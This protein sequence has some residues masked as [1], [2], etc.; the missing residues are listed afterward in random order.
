[1]ETKTERPVLKKDWDLFFTGDNETLYSCFYLFYNDLYRL[2]LF[3]FKNPDI[4]R[5]SIHNLFLELYEVWEVPRNVYNKKQYVLTV[6]RKVS[7]RTYN[8]YASKDAV[9]RPFEIWAPDGHKEVSYEDF[10]IASQVEDYRKK[11]LLHV[12]HKLTRRQKE[13][14]RLRFFEGHSYREIARMTSLSERTIYNTLHNAICYLRKHLT[15]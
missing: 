7:Y 10:L 14:I 3:W 2:G 13:V 9:G 11:Q 15:Y 12:L 1:M 4:A 5:E 6:F 8:N